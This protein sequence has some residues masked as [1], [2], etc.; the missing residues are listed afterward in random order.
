MAALEI[1]A[2]VQDRHAKGPA[3][4][5]DVVFHMDEPIY[6]EL[7]IRWWMAGRMVPGQ[8]DEEWTRLVAQAGRAVQDG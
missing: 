8:P 6:L 7:M 5:G 4:C 3:R 1:P 2:Q